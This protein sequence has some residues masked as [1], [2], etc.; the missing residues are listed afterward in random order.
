MP[1]VN[2]QN[3]VKRNGHH[4]KADINK[5]SRPAKARD[6]LKL[7]FAGNE[8]KGPAKDKK[9]NNLHSTNVKSRSTTKAT[10][11][12]RSNEENETEIED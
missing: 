10:N 9:K 12:K 7:D 3:Q 11:S 8:N 1:N 5:T 2:S 6:D 4:T